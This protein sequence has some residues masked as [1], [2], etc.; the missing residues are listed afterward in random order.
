LKEDIHRIGVSPSGLPIY[1]F[2]YI[3]GGPVYS[4]VMAQDL[5]RLRPDAVITTESG[6]MK[7]DYS[8]IDVRMQVVG[9]TQ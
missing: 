6:Y 1:T 4:G 3:W 5:M 9:A 7:V 2:R 8:R